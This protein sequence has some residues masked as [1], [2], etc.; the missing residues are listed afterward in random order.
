MSV[1]EILSAIRELPEPERQEVL[2]AI[3]AEREREVGEWDRLTEAE[4]ARVRALV[5]E[6]LESGPPTPLDMQEVI[7]EARAEWEARQRR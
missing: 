4:E 3:E 2:D 1:Q 7:R 6:G 5:Q